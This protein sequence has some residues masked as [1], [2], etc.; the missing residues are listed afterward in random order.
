MRLAAATAA[1]KA[2]SVEQYLK[3]VSP[4]TKTVYQRPSNYLQFNVN[5]QGARALPASIVQQQ[6]QQQIEN[7][8]PKQEQF[9]YRLQ[10]EPQQE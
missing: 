5:Q 8:Q 10:P 4:T 6:Q 7:S 1:R 2:P 9:Q 3:E